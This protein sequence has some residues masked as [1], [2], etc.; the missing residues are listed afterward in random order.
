M[1]WSC[2]LIGNFEVSV[3]RREFQG[4]QKERAQELELLVI[5]YMERF[6]LYKRKQRL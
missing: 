1:I 5:I 4:R 3:S 6:N 2:R